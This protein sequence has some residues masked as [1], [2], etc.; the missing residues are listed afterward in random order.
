MSTDC[1]EH[2]STEDFRDPTPEEMEANAPIEERMLTAV[3]SIRCRLHWR[4][5]NKVD[6]QLAELEAYFYQAIADRD[7]DLGHDNPD[8]DDPFNEEVR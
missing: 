8:F 2:Y 3:R 1:G 7:R 6:R 4:E 5:V